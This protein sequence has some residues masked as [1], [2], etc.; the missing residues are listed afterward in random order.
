[1][2]IET[3]YEDVEI[4]VFVEKKSIHLTKLSKEN[5]SLNKLNKIRT[6]INR[7]ITKEASEYEIHIFNAA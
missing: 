7:D 5:L 2:A 3:K 1:M 4:K 6:K